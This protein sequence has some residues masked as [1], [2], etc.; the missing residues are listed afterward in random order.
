M[1][2]RDKLKEAFPHAKPDYIDALVNGENKLTLAGI[3]DNERRTNHFLAQG[4]AET[5]GFTI[6]EESGAYTAMGLLRVFPKYF[7]S[8]AEAKAYAK[9]PQAIF[10]KTYG[11]RLG[12][13]APGD[14]Y[15]YRGR[16]IFQITGKGAYKEY[17]EKLNLDLVNHPEL[18]A[19][20]EHSLEIAIAYWSD[21][22]LNEYADSDD[23][24]AVSR[25][26]NG[27][28]PKRNIQPNGMVDRKSWYAKIKKVM[29]DPAPH[30]ESLIAPG[31]LR[32]GDQGSE[33]ERLQSA[34]RAKGYPAGNIDGVYGTNT[35]K[36]VQSFQTD[37]MHP[38]GLPNGVWLAEYWPVLDAI[39][40]TQIERQTV[41]ASDL[42][43]AGDP[44][45]TGLTWAQ[46]IL[47]FLGFGGAITGGASEGATN[48]PALVGQYQ[49][50]IDTLS[51]M[52]HWVASNGWLLVALGAL[53]TWFLARWAIQHIVKS[54]Q[55]FDYQGPYKEVK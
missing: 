36:A 33:V 46:R 9:R 12:N 38:D 21:L 18:A 51:P 47:M 3:F 10:N 43:Q 22:K 40:N 6:Y 7:K 19:I 54:Y 2:N 5:G 11:N 17:G 52:F 4:G 15:K 1:L 16:G 8:L 29:G 32:E 27:G 30:A 25:G 44:A 26:I 42:H 13:T 55:H 41:T 39:Q 14:G 35:V 37:H 23:I 34:L 28:N 53:A 20:P 24:L 49:P 50:V 31:T 45:V 48:F